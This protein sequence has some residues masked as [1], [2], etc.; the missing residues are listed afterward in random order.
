L[1][2]EPKKIR[3]HGLCLL[4]EWLRKRLGRGGNGRLRGRWCLPE[5]RETA[6][7]ASHAPNEHLFA[8]YSIK[9][10]FLAIM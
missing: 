10:S 5:I 9:G 3:E 4:E 8:N 1:A 6:L 2:R 7:G